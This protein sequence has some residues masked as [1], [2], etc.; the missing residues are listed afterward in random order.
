MPFKSSLLR[1]AGKFFEVFKNSNLSLRGSTQS[2]RVITVGLSVTGGN[3]SYTYGGKK[4]HVWTSPGP[5]VVTGGPASLEYFVVAGGGSG[6]GVNKVIFFTF[7]SL[8]A[9]M[10][11]VIGVVT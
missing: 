1:S 8:K 5:F 7:I 11:E 10:A 4:I 6:Y 3:T 2:T 9:L